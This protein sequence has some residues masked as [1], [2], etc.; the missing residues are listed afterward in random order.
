[1]DS[2]RGVR[3]MYDESLRGAADGFPGGQH[4][5]PAFRSAPESPADPEFLPGQLIPE[6]RR[7]PEG[8]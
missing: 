4:P 1:M 3:L 6:P 8:D 7:S 2:G 5:D